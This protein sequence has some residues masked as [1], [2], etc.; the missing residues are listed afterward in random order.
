M[1]K[2]S[3]WYRYRFQPV[4]GI[5]GHLGL[6]YTLEDP[7]ESAQSD[8]L[9]RHLD[10]GLPGD[11][12]VAGYRHS[13]ARYCAMVAPNGVGWPPLRTPRGRVFVATDFIAAPRGLGEFL[14]NRSP[15]FWGDCGAYRQLGPNS[16]TGLRLTLQMCERSTGYTFEPL[17]RRFRIGAFGWGWRGELRPGQGPY[18]GYF[19][20]DAFRFNSTPAV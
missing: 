11:R 19:S 5:W 20:S 16:N 14:M 15:R 10:Y 8:F 4:F 1:A 7:S 18:P 13:I 6:D 3:F 12:T 17:P 9:L 2:A